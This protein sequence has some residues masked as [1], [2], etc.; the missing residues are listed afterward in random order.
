[1][2]VKK[3]KKKKHNINKSAFI[4]DTL[5]K[6]SPSTLNEQKE[7]WNRGSNWTEETDV[8]AAVNLDFSNDD[9]LRKTDAN[10]LTLPRLNPARCSETTHAIIRGGDDVW[11]SV[12]AKWT[13]NITKNTV[14]Q[15]S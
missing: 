15:A 1:M 13:I 6:W 2:I 14:V 9:R 10:S 5:I 12:P 11:K 4:Y 7:E 8:L 3:K